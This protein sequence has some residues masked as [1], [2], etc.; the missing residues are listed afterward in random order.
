MTECVHQAMSGTKVVLAA[1]ACDQ[2]FHYHDVIM[3][4]L[5]FTAEPT[6][7]QR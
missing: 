5:A 1:L 7:D 3:E 6:W 4:W 2:M